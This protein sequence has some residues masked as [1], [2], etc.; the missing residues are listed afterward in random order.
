MDEIWQNICNCI[1]VDDE[2]NDDS[3]MFAIKIYQNDFNYLKEY[4]EKI[5]DATIKND[6]FIIACVYS[7]NIDIIDFLIDNFKIDVNCVNRMSK[8]NCLLI[9]CLKNSSLDRIKWLAYSE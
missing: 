8:N 7:N 3:K 2:Y 4:Y 1:E 9:C 6:C 5:T